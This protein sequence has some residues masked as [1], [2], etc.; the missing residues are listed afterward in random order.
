[1]FS[2]TCNLYK[3]NAQINLWPLWFSGWNDAFFCA[4]EVWNSCFGRMHYHLVQNVKI[5]G[6]EETMKPIKCN[7]EKLKN[8][9]IK[10]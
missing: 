4:D 1:M 9:K 5:Q 2:N 10:E 6:L 7:K 8:S 3:N